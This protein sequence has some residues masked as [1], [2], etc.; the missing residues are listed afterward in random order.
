VK[1]RR[2]KFSERVPADLT[3]NRITAAPADLRSRGV[4]ITDLI[5]SNR[6]VGSSATTF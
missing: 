1:T 5:E 3:P 4:P 2:T 6:R